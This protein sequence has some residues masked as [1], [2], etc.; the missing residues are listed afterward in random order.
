[1]NAAFEKLTSLV[2]DV[3]SKSEY[4]G[5][6]EPVAERHGS[7]EWAVHSAWKESYEEMN[8]YLTIAVTELGSWYE[9]EFWAGAEAF[10]Y[11]DLTEVY[12]TKRKIE[13]GL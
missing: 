4:L 7:W 10:H 13:K 8:L 2:K 11:D 1:M 12:P 6:V 3:P 9:V 5:V